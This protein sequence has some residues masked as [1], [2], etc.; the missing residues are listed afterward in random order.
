MDRELTIL[1][2]ASATSSFAAGVFG[3]LFALFVQK[4]GGGATAAGY[5]FSVYAIGAGLLLYVFARLEDHIVREDL[6][7]VGGFALATA[8]YIG[9]IFVG[10]LLHLLVVQAVLGLA[11]AIRYPAF[12]SMYSKHLHQGSYASEWGLF[13]SLQWI[14]AGIS[15]AAGG[16]IV[17]T[18]GFTTLFGLMGALQAGATVVA[19]SL[20]QRPG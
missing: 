19:F 9:Y 10:S 18:W 17:A 14:V 12:D 4:V 16:L 3:P 8:G 11:V 15:A 2:V 5:A 1:N 20:L 6:L 7:V 13:E